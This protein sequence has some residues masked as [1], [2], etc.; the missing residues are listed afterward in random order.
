M[1]GNRAGCAECAQRCRAL[2]PLPLQGASVLW[3]VSQGKSDGIYSA[4]SLPF[5]QC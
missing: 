1:S 2:A 4:V 3:V 5:N